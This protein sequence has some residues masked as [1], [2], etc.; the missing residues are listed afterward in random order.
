MT[1][2]RPL[3]AFSNREGKEE[4][5][6]VTIGLS[7][8]RSATAYLKSMAYLSN[9]RGAMAWSELLRAN[10]NLPTSAWGILL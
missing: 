6:T 10:L 3:H 1:G 8:R 4:E 5:I 9:H 7:I 2:R